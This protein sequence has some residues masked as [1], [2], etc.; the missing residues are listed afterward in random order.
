[1]SEIDASR[2]LRI[3]L[4]NRALALGWALKGAC[5]PCAHRLFTTARW[6]VPE[7]QRFLVQRPSSHNRNQRFFEWLLSCIQLRIVTGFL[8]VLALVGALD[9]AMRTTITVTQPRVESSAFRQEPQIPSE[10]NIASVSKSS[11]PMQDLVLETG[12]LSEEHFAPGPLPQRKPRR[13][14]KVSNGKGAKANLASQTRMA[15]QKRALTKPM[16]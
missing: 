11:E 7:A 8:I 15:Q 16:R 1:M 6:L 3:F 4:A 10:S 5:K 2:R 14:Y 9:F 12:S 13:A